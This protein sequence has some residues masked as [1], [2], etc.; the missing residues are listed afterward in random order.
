MRACAIVSLILIAAAAT[1]QTSTVATKAYA[2]WKAVQAESNA[3][4][5]SRVE[6]TNASA[7]AAAAIGAIA[8]YTT[9]LTIMLDGKAS[10]NEAAIRSAADTALLASNVLARAAITNEATIRATIDTAISNQVVA[11]PRV[12]TN[13][14]TGWL[15]YD[16]G[17][18][19]WLRVSVSNY[20]YYISEVL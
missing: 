15:L 9:N 16:S 6:I 14:V 10:T 17:S 12:P 5:R 19:K 11:L 3:V 20:S 1:A 8:A 18:N 13:A 7:S 4:F 2:D